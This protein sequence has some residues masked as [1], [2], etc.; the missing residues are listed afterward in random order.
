MTKENTY[1]PHAVGSAHHCTDRVVIVPAVRGINRNKNLSGRLRQLVA[2]SSKQRRQVVLGE[3]ALTRILL[4]AVHLSEIRVLVCSELLQLLDA[5]LVLVVRPEVDDVRTQLQALLALARLARLV[6]GDL[7][8][9]RQIWIVWIALGDC[10]SYPAGVVSRSGG[11]DARDVCERSNW[12]KECFYEFS[13]KHECFVNYHVAVEA[14][15]ALK[16][17]EKKN[18]T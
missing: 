10:L 7:W 8:N 15:V 4:D 16:K 17:I 14:A 11:E 2:W 9:I 18:K 13:L 5:V 1:H 6:C 3:V 12:Q